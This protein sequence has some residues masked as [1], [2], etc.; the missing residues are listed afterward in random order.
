MAS[1]AQG[2]SSISASG[3]APQPRRPAGAPDSR[4]PAKKNRPDT[5]SDRKEKAPRSKLGQMSGGA[6]KN[7]PVDRH[8]GGETRPARPATRRA[9]RGRIVGQ[10]S[11]WT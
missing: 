3:N 7:K 9:R 4:W 5:P 11:R 8:A 6:E 2:T 10:E 1:A